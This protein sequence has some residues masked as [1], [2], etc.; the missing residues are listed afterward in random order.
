MDD[1]SFVRGF[2]RKSD[3]PADVDRVFERHRALGGFA[4]YQLH[5]DVVRADV[6]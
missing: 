4:L 5:H 3:L 1:A 6:V 2:E